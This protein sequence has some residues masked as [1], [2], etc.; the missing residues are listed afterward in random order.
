[1]SFLKLRDCDII[2]TI[3]T[4]HPNYNFHLTSSEN[5]V[6]DPIYVFNST[7]VGLGR[8]FSDLR[9]NAVKQNYNLS[10]SVSYVSTTSVTTR[11]KN[12]LDRLRNI[13]ASSSFVKVDNYI[14]SSLNGNISFVNIPQTLYD[15][16]LKPGSILLSNEIGD[17]YTDDGYGG[18]FTGSLHVGCVFY[19]HGIIYLGPKYIEGNLNFTASFS[20]SHNIPMNLY[21]CRV[22]RGL[23]NYSSNPSYTTFLTSSNSNEITTSKP[24]T[25]ITSV[26]LYDEDHKL[27]G[28]AKVSSPIL[29]E[30]ETGLLFRCK[31]AF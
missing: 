11:E 16:R 12:S 28:V 15:S 9:G 2:S 23:L 5:Y 3:Y 10:G 30:E 20:G 25:F 22:P 14:S 6:S 1:M 31:I 21:L 29:N 13:Y 4:T 8:S 26:G 27:V 24:K 19:Q 7:S 18:I 17:F